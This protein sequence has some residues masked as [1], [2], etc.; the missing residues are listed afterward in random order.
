[1]CFH[2]LLAVLVVGAPSRGLE[3]CRVLGG[4]DLASYDSRARRD[5]V[6]DSSVG[7]CDVLL[8]DGDL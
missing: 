3:P 6:A 4:V 2:C 1:M 7:A 8:R 5:D